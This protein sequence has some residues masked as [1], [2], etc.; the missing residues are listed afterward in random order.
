M[1]KSVIHINPKEQSNTVSIKE[2]ILKCLKS[3]VDT[4]NHIYNLFSDDI[5]NKTQSFEESINDATFT[6]ESLKDDG[7][8]IAK[9]PAYLKSKIPS[10]PPQLNH[11]IFSHVL[12]F[13]YEIQGHN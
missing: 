10:Q 1:I 3:F 7:F 6:I 2:R 11:T 9:I 5:N 8:L 13:R 4:V 12:L